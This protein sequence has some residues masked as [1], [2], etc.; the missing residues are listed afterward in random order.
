MDV[1]LSRTAVPLRNPF[2]TFPN[3]SFGRDLFRHGEEQ[4][5]QGGNTIRQRTKQF[6]MFVE[7][8]APSGVRLAR[9]DI[10]VI[11][12][13]PGDDAKTGFAPLWAT[14]GVSYDYAAAGLMQLALAGNGTGCGG[15]GAKPPA[16][17]QDEFKYAGLSPEGGA[18]DAEILAALLNG[19][20][21]V[22]VS[23]LTRH[24]AAAAE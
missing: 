1:H 5:R 19:V 23:L 10:A 21:L 3:I 12:C 14:A 17:P 15:G 22:V 7:I 20:T 11:S 24:Q 6:T 8:S 13:L 4:A 18:S 16:G 2:F 9:R